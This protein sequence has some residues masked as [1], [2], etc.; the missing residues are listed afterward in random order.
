MGAEFFSMWGSLF[1]FSFS[2]DEFVVVPILSIG[3][4]RANF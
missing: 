3:C 1:V 4:T 2:L